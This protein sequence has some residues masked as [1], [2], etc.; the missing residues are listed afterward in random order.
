[1]V[2]SALAEPIPLDAVSPSVP[3]LTLLKLAALPAMLPVVAVSWTVFAPASTRPALPKAMLPLAVV[4]V[5]LTGLVNVAL[6]LIFPLP[7][8]SVS[9]PPVRVD[10]FAAPTTV[11]PPVLAEEPIVR[12]L[13]LE[14]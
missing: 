7:V 5:V 1:M 2:S 10:G 11:M 14:I 9:V 8:C 12:P 6:T 4:S 13:A 3:A